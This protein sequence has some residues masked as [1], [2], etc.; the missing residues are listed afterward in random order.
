MYDYKELDN[1]LKTI[2][3]S[4]DILESLLFVQYKLGGFS[5]GEGYFPI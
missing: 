3:S 1:A 5:F 2:N 4:R